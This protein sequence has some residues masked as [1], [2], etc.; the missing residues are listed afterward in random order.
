LSRQI[1]PFAIWNLSLF[2]YKWHVRQYPILSVG[3]GSI[4]AV[5]VV[6]VVVVVA[7]AA[8]TTTT[9]LLRRLP[10]RKKEMLD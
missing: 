6:V 1:H 4:V 8:T 9:I 7:A 2:P 3:Q 10:W 5:L